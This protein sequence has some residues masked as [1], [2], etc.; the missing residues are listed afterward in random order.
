V[1]LQEN[2][3]TDEAPTHLNTICMMLF[4]SNR[5]LFLGRYCRNSNGFSSDNF[6]INRYILD[7]FKGCFLSN[8][9]EKTFFEYQYKCRQGF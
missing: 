2:E 1:H 7:L 6:C 3:G 9:K 5:I 4:H 8:V